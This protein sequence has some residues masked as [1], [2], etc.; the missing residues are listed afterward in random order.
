MAELA[1]A[2]ADGSYR[3]RPQLVAEALLL[4]AEGDRSARPD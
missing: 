3:V 4:K 1:S 2:I